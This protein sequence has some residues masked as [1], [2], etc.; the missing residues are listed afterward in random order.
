MLLRPHPI[1][2]YAAISPFVDVG[3]L[4]VVAD[5]VNIEVPFEGD[6]DVG[7]PSVGPGC[8]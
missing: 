3:S 8:T 6:V 7:G 5:D 4:D 1:I 2:G